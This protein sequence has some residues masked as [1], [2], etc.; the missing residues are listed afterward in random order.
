M[1][2]IIFNPHLPVQIV[3]VNR[4]F[5]SYSLNQFRLG[6]ESECPNVKERG[7][8]YETNLLQNCADLWFYIGLHLPLERYRLIFSLYRF[9]LHC[10]PEVILDADF[11]K[12]KNF[13]RFHKFPLKKSSYVCNNVIRIQH[14]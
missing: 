7:L 5:Y 13:I 14:K 3:N 9:P 11:I 4:V 10:L 2:H 8:K 1:E 12:G 6:N